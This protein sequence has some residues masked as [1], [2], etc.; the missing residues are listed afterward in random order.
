M[1]GPRAVEAVT[2]DLEDAGIALETDAYAELVPGHVTTVLLRPSDRSFE[3]GRVLAL[4]RARRPGGLG[5]RR[6]HRLP[7]HGPHHGRAASL[8]ARAPRASAHRPDPS[9]DALHGR[10]WRGDGQV[11]THALWWPPKGGRGV[12]Q[13]G[14][15]PVQMDLHHSVVAVG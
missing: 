3:V 2:A 6:R 8:P 10:R 15:V 5:R 7:G 4:P 12:P 1:F 9:L 14:G 11:S 13:S